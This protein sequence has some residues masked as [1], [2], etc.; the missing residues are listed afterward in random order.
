[1][2]NYFLGVCSGTGLISGPTTMA[3][4]EMQRSLIARGH[5]V[6]YGVHAQAD[7][8]IARNTLAHLFLTSGAD[9]F[10]GIDDDVGIS[11]QAFEVMTAQDHDC[12]VAIVPQRLLDLGRFADRIRAGDDVAQAQRKAAPPRDLPPEQPHGFF[13]AERGTTSFYMVRRSVYERVAASGHVRQLGWQTEQGLVPYWGFYTPG[14]DER[15]VYLSED[16]AFFRRVRRSGIAITAWHGPGLSHS[17][18]KTYHS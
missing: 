17:G 10:V 9:V 8:A 6:T 5:G 12:L 16:Y 4:L 13:E 11:L 2:T 1:M 3:L 18:L 15:G 7:I 14:E